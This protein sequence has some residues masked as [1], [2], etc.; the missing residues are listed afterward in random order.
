MAALVHYGVYLKKNGFYDDY[1]E[2]FKQK[3]RT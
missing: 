3:V 2:Q 1:I